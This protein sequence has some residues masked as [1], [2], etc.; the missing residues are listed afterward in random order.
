M[1]GSSNFDSLCDLLTYKRKE[2]HETRNAVITRVVSVISGFFI[3]K[4]KKKMPAKKTGRKLFNG[5]D[6]KTVVQKLEQVWTFGGSDKEAAFYAEISPAALSDYLKKNP[7]ISERKEA[8]KN[9]PILKAREELIKGLKDNPELAL[10]YLERKLPDEF[11]LKNIL[12]HKENDRPINIRFIRY[13]KK[14]DG[15]KTD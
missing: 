2:V 6:E 1:G 3:E 7:L 4:E 5:K 13:K 15:S 14:E 9:K 8:L 10:K 12:E 11:A